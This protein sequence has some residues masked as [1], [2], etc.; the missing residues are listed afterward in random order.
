LLTVHEVLQAD[1]HEVWHSWHSRGRSLCHPAEKT[2][3]TCSCLPV[4]TLH[5]TVGHLPATGFPPDPRRIILRP[6]P[7]LPALNR[8]SPPSCEKWHPRGGVPGAGGRCGTRSI[9]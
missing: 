4:A 1:W 9:W 3:V 7:A 2:T 8:D 6:R 5:T